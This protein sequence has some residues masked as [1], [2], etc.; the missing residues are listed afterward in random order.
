MAQNSDI[1][2]GLYD[3]FAKG[4]IPAVLATLASDIS[5]TEAEGGPY[6]GVSI[7]SARYSNGN[8]ISVVGLE[9]SIS[10]PN[11]LLWAVRSAGAEWQKLT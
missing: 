1:I 7:G 4:D 3:A 10:H 9:N 6:G 2:R 11:I 8:A 5:W